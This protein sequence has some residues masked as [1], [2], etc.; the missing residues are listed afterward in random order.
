MTFELLWFVAAC[1]S[2][3]QNLLP[4]GESEKWGGDNI[5]VNLLV[6]LLHPKTL[7]LFSTYSFYYTQTHPR[8]HMH[9]LPRTNTHTHTHEGYLV[10][11][12]FAL[13]GSSYKGGG[14]LAIYLILTSNVAKM[15][16]NRS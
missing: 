14:S 2:A 5:P 3:P 16:K 12:M 1:I 9:P 6:R 7:L 11:G 13:L 4:E 8:I 15:E 10:C